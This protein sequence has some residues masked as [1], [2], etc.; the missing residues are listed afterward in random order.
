M[1]AM[2][3]PP[4]PGLAPFER[5]GAILLTTYKRD[6]T[7]VGTPM[8]IAVD[9]D[10]AYFRTYGDAWKTKRMRNFPEV[11]ICP[12]TWRG[13]PPGP[14]SRHGCGCWIRRPGST[15]GPNAR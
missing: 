10:H 4:S 15:G 5:Q 12:S 7:G 2:T 1:G 3:N 14:P 8:N 13:G 6:G 11:E 9:G